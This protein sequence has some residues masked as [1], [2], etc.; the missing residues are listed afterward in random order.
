MR[1]NARNLTEVCGPQKLFVASEFKRF[2]QYA[3]CCS[4]AVSRVDESSPSRDNT[5]VGSQAFAAF[6]LTYAGEEFASTELTEAAVRTSSRLLSNSI[7]V[8]STDKGGWS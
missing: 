3:R 5:E 6:V 1:G 8:R 4:P 7:I 2:A